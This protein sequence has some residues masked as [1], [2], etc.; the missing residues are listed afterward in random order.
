MRF[1]LFLITM[2]FLSGCTFYNPN[3]QNFYINRSL[4]KDDIERIKTLI[5]KDNKK[6][7]TKR[8]VMIK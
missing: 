8:N 2:G 3:I 6:A 5:E 1:I 4:G 7:S